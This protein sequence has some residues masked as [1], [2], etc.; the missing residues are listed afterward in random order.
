MHFHINTYHQILHKTNSKNMHN[1]IG[2]MVIFATDESHP[3]I[4]KTGNI[5]YLYNVTKRTR[6]Y[7]SRHILEKFYD[8]LRECGDFENWIYINKNWADDE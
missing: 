6:L 5:C 2:P 7:L 4:S 3:N 8:Y 1:I